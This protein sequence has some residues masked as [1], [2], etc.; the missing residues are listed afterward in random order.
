VSNVA[1][2][3]VRA[4]RNALFVVFTLCGMGLSSWMARGP[5]IREALGIDTAQYGLLIVC[6]SI[7]SILGLLAA[8]HLGTA[9]GAKVV[10][11]TAL[12]I[13]T[14][15][16]VVAGC[17]TAFAPNPFVVAGGLFLFGISASIVDVNM[18]ISGAANE[19]ALGRTIMPIY[20]AFF[21]GGAVL[22]AGVGALAELV[23]LSFAAHVIIVGALLAGG[24]IG[25]SL[26]LLPENQALAGGHLDEEEAKPSVAERLAMWRDPRTLMIGLIVLGMAFAEGT[27]NDWLAIA[28]V[29]GHGVDESTGAVSLALFVGSMTVGRIAGVRILDRFGR[30]PVLRGSAALAVLGLLLV[31]VVP[32]DVVAI[33]GVVLWG[34]GASLGF[35]V[36]M[37]AAADDPRTATATVGAVATIGYTAFLVGP[38]LIG[39]IGEHTGV[40]RALLVVLVLIVVGGFAS[41]AAREPGAVRR[42]VPAEGAQ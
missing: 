21:S 36:G 34:V 30:V 3:P 26:F 39:L 24:A 27:A 13:G 18:N 9:F 8:G 11:R 31:I 35:P 33:V 12:P 41:G 32:N 25:A 42:P 2:A 14:V 19:R 37:S 20:H 1:A 28:M 5:S 6:F 40:L 23:D 38:P 22:G 29:D 7:G 10:I 17:S 16:F 15:G 4:W